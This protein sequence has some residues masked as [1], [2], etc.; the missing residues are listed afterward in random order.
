MW[1]CTSTICTRR[2]SVIEAEQLLRVVMQ[3][4]VGNF[5]QQAEPLD[6]GKGLPVD[7]PILQHRIV[8]A[9]H[10]LIEAERFEGT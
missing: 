9:G 3:D 8:A 1:L 7:L 5:L 2:L 10:E 4:L 6:M